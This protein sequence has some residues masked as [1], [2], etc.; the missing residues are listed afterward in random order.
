MIEKSRQRSF[1]K[2]WKIVSK[3]KARINF[4]LLAAFLTM[5]AFSSCLIVKEQD[6]EV[7]IE[8]TITLSPKPEIPMSEDLVRSKT[9][10]MIAFIPRNWFFVDVE[11]KAS[12]EIIA[13]AVNPDYSLGA[14]FSS[15]R[16]ND[17]LDS[18]VNK[19]GLYGLARMSLTN[20]E[21][22]TAG[23]V[24]LSGKYRQVEM[25]ICKFVTYKF[26]SPG[27]SMTSESAVFISELG[28]YYE[29]SLIPMNIKGEPLPPIEEA[30]KIFRSI[31]TTIKY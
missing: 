13:V 16:K 10:D 22:K 9:G 30:E 1:F 19:E 15:I 4:K 26:T 12:P 27:G 23:A 18:T 7:Q 3:L 11:D 17:R 6:N 29:F 25:G 31:L 21:R 5:T 14:V 8:P 24:K 28:Q 20:R 2:E